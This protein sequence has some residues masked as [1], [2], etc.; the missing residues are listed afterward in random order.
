MTAVC[1]SA[2]SIP[3]SPCAEVYVSETTHSHMFRD[4]YKTIACGSLLSIHGVALVGREQCGIRTYHR[5]ALRPFCLL[6][7]G[8]PDLGVLP[9][10]TRFAR[11]SPLDDS[12]L[13]SKVNFNNVSYIDLTAHGFGFTRVTRWRR[14]DTTACI[15]QRRL[16]SKQ[17]ATSLHL[18]GT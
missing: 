16:H 6:L 18:D 9:K 3:P 1:R 10:A 13:T 11:P 14:I 15:M 5:R 8:S 7:V 2:I 4:L 17:S 12:A